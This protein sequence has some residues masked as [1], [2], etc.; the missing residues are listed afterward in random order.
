MTHLAKNLMTLSFEVILAIIGFGISTWFLAEYS[1]EYEDSKCID[2][3]NSSDCKKNAV[4]IAIL[5]IMVLLSIILLVWG[6]S[7]C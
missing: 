6:V 2:N 5:S 4:Q 1:I 3:Q 7:T